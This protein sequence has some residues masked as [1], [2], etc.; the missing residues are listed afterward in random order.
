ER[1][2]KQVMVA[3]KSDERKHD[4]DCRDDGERFA[5][6]DD[7]K[8]EQNEQPSETQR[9]CLERNKQAQ[10]CKLPPRSKAVQCRRKGCGRTEPEPSRNDEFAFAEKGDRHAGQCTDQNVST[11]KRI[12]HVTRKQASPGSQHP[13]PSLPDERL[14]RDI[15]EKDETRGI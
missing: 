6:K 11:N 3:W 10:A 5:T 7:S 2:F 14:E 1:D 8:K 4:D 12:T 13:R 15:H 9:Q